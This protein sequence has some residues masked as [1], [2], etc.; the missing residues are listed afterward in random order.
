MQFPDQLD[1]KNMPKHIAFIM[2]GNGRWANKRSLF[3]TMGHKVGVESVQKIVRACRELGVEVVTLYAFSSENWQRPALE[4]TTL[5]SL[6]KTYLKK[7]LAS[8]LKNN[9][10]LKCMGQKERLPD[11]VQDILNKTIEDT[12]NNSGMV[13]NLALSYGSR[14]EILH[15]VKTIA[16]EYKAN[17]ISLDDIN[18][19][20][21]SDNLFTKGL[22]D[23]DLIIRTGGESRLSNFLLWQASYSE[24]FITETHW[25]DFR[26]KSLIESIENFQQR[27]RRFGKTGAQVDKSN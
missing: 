10:R 25:P 17:N 2:D 15:A 1:K 27:Q 12:A 24:I 22:P 16:S 9:I 3:R 18:E 7:E 13:L 4:V 14:N 8:M 20:T 19:Q 26:E 23:P 5:M 6:L 21:I 11:D